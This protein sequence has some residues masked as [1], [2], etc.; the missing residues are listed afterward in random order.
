MK[1]ESNLNKKAIKEIQ[2]DI[3]K[4]KNP[5]EH[6]RPK[7]Y[8]NIE[9]KLDSKQNIMDVYQNLSQ[10]DQKIVLQI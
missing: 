6:V 10:E 3:P 5:Y 8:E 1:Y 9:N 2:L 7:V 4:R